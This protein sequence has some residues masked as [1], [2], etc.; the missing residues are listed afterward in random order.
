MGV[1]LASLLAAACWGTADFIGGFATRAMNLLMVLLLVNL[2]IVGVSLGAT[3]LSGGP[4]LGRPVILLA[5]AGGVCGVIGSGA[6]YQAL[7]LGKMGVVAPIPAVGVAIP[8]VAGWLAGDRFSVV[9]SVGMAVAVAGIILVSIE[10]SEAEVETGGRQARWAIAFALLAAVG[11]GSQYLLTRQGFSQDIPQTLLAGR[12]LPVLATL[13]AVLAMRTAPPGPRPA[14]LCVAGGAWETGALVLVGV[15]TTLGSI[16]VVAV[17]TSLYPAMT[18]LLATVL[19]RER[20]R[21]VQALGAAVTLAG[22]VL[23]AA[24]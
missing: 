11:L 13:V 21:P 14:A 18:A 17:L 10:S 19:L 15:A 2:T 16:G 5:V 1:V 6:Y 7:A 8:V 23:I 24:G 12:M 22:V 3:L 4:V 9:V 20:L